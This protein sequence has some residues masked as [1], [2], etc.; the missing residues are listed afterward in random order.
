MM[1]TGDPREAFE[2]Y[3]TAY[4]YDVRDWGGYPTLRSIRELRAT[5]V[6]FQL[7]DQGTIPLHQA[8]Y[9][10][11]CLRGHHGPRPWAW[12]TIA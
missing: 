4:G 8:R 9:R 3:C 2:A 10:L 12:T 6:A 5:T 11:A 7:A 1:H